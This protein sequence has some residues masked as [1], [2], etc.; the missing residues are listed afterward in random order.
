M[1][2]RLPDRNRRTRRI[3]EDSHTAV[4]C[5]IKGL[6]DNVCTE[7]TGFGS[8]FTTITEGLA[9]TNYVMSY[10][11][12][13][14]VGSQFNLYTSR[15]SQAVPSASLSGDI[16]GQLIFMGWQTARRTGAGGCAG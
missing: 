10:V 12:A 7:L 1:F 8:G 4:V 16:L 6:D 9:A 3:S 2:L 13:G 11:S 15:G 5:N 14:N